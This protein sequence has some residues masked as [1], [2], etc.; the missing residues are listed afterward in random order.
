[1]NVERRTS[2]IQ[3]RTLN[4]LSGR[5]V[6]VLGLGVS[7]EA[8]AELLLSRGAVVTVLDDETGEELKVRAERLR[9]IGGAVTLGGDAGRIGEEVDFLV[10][11]P[12]IPLSH[13]LVR[14]AR[15]RTIP[16]MGELEM[17]YRLLNRPLIAVTGTNGKTTTVSLIHEIFRQGG[18]PSVTGGNIG[19]PLSRIVLAG[20]KDRR[21]VVEVSSFQLER[22]EKFRPSVAILLNLTS[23]HLDRYSGMDEYRAAKLRIFENQGPGDLAAVPAH[24]LGLL[25][26]AVFP[27]VEKATWGGRAG[28]VVI[29]DGIL[30][31]GRGP[32]GEIICRVE[33]IALKGEH[34]LANIMAAVTVGINQDIGAEAIKSALVSFEGL[35]HRLEYVS[36]PGGV[37]YYND[38]K[39]TNPA[40]VAAALNS[41][42]RPVIWLAGGS[43]KGLDP[44]PL[45]ESLPGPIK[46]ALLMG[47][48]GDGLRRLVEGEIPFRMVTDMKEAVAVASR[49]AEA[50]D[51]VLL[52]PGY[53]SF[54]MFKNY[55]ERGDV[56]KS[57][58]MGLTDPKERTS[59]TNI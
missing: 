49:E 17:A 58:V 44:A 6:M 18:I 12:G 41:F 34:N 31:A 35:P 14:E 33:E 53:A 22:I 51:I 21:V 55:R 42:S 50:G 38:S 54:D 52:S 36:S 29:E 15:E 16:V 10:V 19:H 27:G 7:G 24:L 47:E 43:D 1:M 23:D 45:K 32:R 56:F 57:L 8:A 5:K 9:S 40:A 48:S 25:E 59:N 46:L 3:H 26:T 2:N 37:S 13:R 30:R 20:D 4:T 28:R 39:A 11:S